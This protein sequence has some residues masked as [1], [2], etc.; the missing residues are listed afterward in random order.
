MMFSRCISRT[1]ERLAALYKHISCQ[2]PLLCPYGVESTRYSRRMRIARTMRRALVRARCQLVGPMPGFWHCT[3]YSSRNRESLGALWLVS[4]IL[5]RIGLGVI[6]FSPIKRTA[7][8]EGHIS[9][10]VNSGLLRST[11]NCRRQLFTRWMS[12]DQTTSK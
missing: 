12:N 7:Q 1:S 6:D 4:T 10:N 3:S 8:T 11:Q 5:R 2:M 9:S